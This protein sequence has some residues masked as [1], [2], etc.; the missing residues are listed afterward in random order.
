MLEEQR[1]G[2]ASKTSLLT[3][4]LGIGVNSSL[5]PIV[6]AVPLKPLPYT[7]PK[8]LTA[9]YQRA[10]NFEKSSISYL[11]FLDWQAGNRTFVSMAA[12]RSDNSNLTGMG[13][14]S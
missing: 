1:R 8:V 9:I 11:N 14:S 6:S 3:P 13:D 5:F 2:S 10:Y 7:Q 12:Y 4:A